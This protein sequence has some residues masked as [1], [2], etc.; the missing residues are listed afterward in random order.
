MEGNSELVLLIS[1][2]LSYSVLGL[3][4]FM[5]L[6]QISAILSSKSTRGMNSKSLWMEL[7]ACL[8]GLSY[9][10]AHGFHITTYMEAGFLVIQ[11]AVIIF[12][13]VSYESKWTLENGLYAVICAVYSIV[14]FFKL[15]PFSVL[16]ILLISTLPLSVFS[17]LAQ[18]KTIY[19]I[20]SCGNISI[21]SWLIGT[22][23][24]VARLCTSY[25]E[26]N[27]MQIL[28]NFTILS[29]LNVMVVLMCLYY[30]KEEQI[31]KE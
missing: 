31:K 24:C 16:Q 5:K 18:M 15:I 17:I 3:C 12:L 14:S 27:D 7:G 23:F 25:I 2:F 13:I 6:P 1:R 8:I 9:G 21:L 19:Q 28:F 10:Y 20:K 29:I 22:Y 26:V 4:F 11:N 30:G